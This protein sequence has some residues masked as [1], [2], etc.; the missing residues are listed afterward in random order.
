M[1]ALVQSPWASRLWLVACLLFLWAGLQQPAKRGIYF[2]IAAVFG[3]IAA[4][5]RP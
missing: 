2:S 5:Q 4:R 3:I 1:E